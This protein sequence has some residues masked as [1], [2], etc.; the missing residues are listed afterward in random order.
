MKKRTFVILGVL[1]LVLGVAA[2]AMAYSKTTRLATCVV[3][4]GCTFETVV[5]N[6]SGAQV[7]VEDLT[8][9]DDVTVGDDI[10]VT[11]DLKVGN[12]TPGLTLNGEDAYVEGTFE[13]DGSVQ[14]DGAVTCNAALIL[15]TGTT[16]PAACTQGQLFH[17][18]DSDDCADTGGGDGALCIC[19]SSNTW[20]LVVN[21]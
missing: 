9:T 21:M 13:V 8:T 5:E 15:Q 3:T 12:G 14:F 2:G 20:A 1:A 4:P 10:T 18:T 11:G 19:K 7:S 16:L 6:V 17:D